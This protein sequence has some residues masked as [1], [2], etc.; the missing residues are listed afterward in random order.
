MRALYYVCWNNLYVESVKFSELIMKKEKEVTIFATLPPLIGI[1]EHVVGRSA[2]LKKYVNFEIISFKS[3]Y[4][5]FLH[6]AKKTMTPEWRFEDSD[7]DYFYIIKYY[8]PL[9]WI[10][11]GLKARGKIFHFHYWN[12]F[13]YF[14]YLPIVIIGKLRKRKILFE[15]HNIETHEKNRLDK[16]VLDWIVDVSDAIVVHTK[17][18][19]RILQS[20]YPEASNKV[21]VIPPGVYNFYG[22]PI[23][24]KLARK[25]LGLKPEDKVVL[26]FGNIRPYKGLE[27]LVDALEILIKKNGKD[28]ILLVAGRD[29]GLWESIEKS[30]Y[31][32]GLQEYVKAFPSYIPKEDV[33]YFFSAA[34]VIVLPY[35]QF[36]SQSA[37]VLVSLNFGLPFLAPDFECFKEFPGEKF[38]FKSGSSDS[39][40]EYIEK[41]F[42]NQSFREELTSIILQKKDE[43]SWSSIALKFKE[44]YEY[45]RGGL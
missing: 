37:V 35:L 33:K 18:M 19:K 38:L 14:F 9:S 10:Y 44:I 41:F 13:L 28:Y 36:S 27:L 30:I 12:S 15:I 6:P 21:F 22:V 31:E 32:K 3:L 7:I 4:P 25:K 23:D 39:I 8:D 43:Y 5:R 42:K 34:D 11:A 2:E 40:A 1:S 20:R 26:F 16:F 24:K 29:W 17:E 45:L